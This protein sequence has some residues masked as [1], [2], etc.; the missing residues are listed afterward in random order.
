MRPFRPGLMLC[1]YVTGVGR[2]LLLCPGRKGERHDKKDALSTSTDRGYG[3]SSMRGGFICGLREGGGYLSGQEWQDSL[4]GLRRE[5]LR[6]LHHQ[7]P[8]RGQAQG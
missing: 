4:F 3:G 2:A 7:L 5:R 1:R 8:R 6:D